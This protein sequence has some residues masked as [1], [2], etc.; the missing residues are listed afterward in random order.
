MHGT[1][2]PTDQGMRSV[3]RTGGRL[4]FYRHDPAAPL[5]AWTQGG[6]GIFA[7]GFPSATSLDS[8]DSLVAVESNVRVGVPRSAV[9]RPVARAIAGKTWTTRF[10]PRTWICRTSPP[11]AR[12]P[13]TLNERGEPPGRWRRDSATG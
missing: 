6:N 13:H 7:S 9:A 10:R 8:G 11:F 12:R 4:V 1:L 5:N 3:A 2:V